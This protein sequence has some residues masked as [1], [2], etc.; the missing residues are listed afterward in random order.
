MHP[1]WG[2]AGTHLP[3][4]T[5][6]VRWSNSLQEIARRKHCHI[7]N[8]RDRLQRVMRT[9]PPP[10]HRRGGCPSPLFRGGYVSLRSLV[11]MTKKAFESNTPNPLG[12]KMWELAARAITQLLESME[13]YTN[14]AVQVRQ[15]RNGRLSAN[16]SARVSVWITDDNGSSVP[17]DNVW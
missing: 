5:P 1:L 17:V 10:P 8:F 13:G 15:G 16:A 4:S 14:V 2:G 6:S 7:A 9:N 3:P 11:M 12:V